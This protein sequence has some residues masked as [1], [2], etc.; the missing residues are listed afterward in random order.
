MGLLALI[1]VLMAAFAS[2]AVLPTLG[3]LRARRR[4]DVERAAEGV[5][6]VDDSALARG[7]AL[8]RAVD[9]DRT[10]AGMNDVARDVDRPEREAHERGTA[11]PDGLVR[12]NGRAVAVAVACIPMACNKSANESTKKL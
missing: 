3:E 9:R 1:G 7:R 11:V 10:G 5:E 12:T 4:Q 8:V 6:F 2:L